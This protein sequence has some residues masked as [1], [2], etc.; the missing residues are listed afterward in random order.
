MPTQ[1]HGCALEG[2]EEETHDT[3]LGLVSAKR[4][5]SHG[6]HPV[7]AADEPIQHPTPWAQEPA[8]P[9]TEVISPNPVTGSSASSGARRK[10]IKAGSA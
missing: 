7:F 3:A 8:A 1:G 9:A 6:D 4:R 2:A 10:L 5:Q